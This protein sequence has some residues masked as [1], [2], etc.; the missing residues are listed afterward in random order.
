MAQAR[1]SGNVV[2]LR[3][4]AAAEPV[5][6]ELAAATGDATVRVLYRIE[7]RPA[8]V[9][10]RDP[11]APGSERAVRGSLADHAVELDGAA[12]A[13][14]EHA[15]ETSPETI[16]AACDVPS[17]EIEHEHRIAGLRTQVR[18]LEGAEQ[19]LRDVFE[20]VELVVIAMDLDARM[21]YVNPFT[22]RLSGWTRDELLGGNWFATFQ[23]GREAFLDRVRAGEFPPRDESTIIV[24][25]GDRRQ[26]DWYN[27]ALRDEEG[28]VEGVLGIGRDTTDELGMQR[29]LEAALGGCT[30]SSRRSSL[31]PAR[32]TSTGGDLC[33][34]VPRPSE[35]LDA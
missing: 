14:I 34:R 28:R 13:A 22:E 11:R 7:E 16:G 27:V 17:A 6:A 24:K 21:T 29:S 25:N 5:A 8:L 20:A 32:S 23:S 3:S 33:Q 1:I 15:A 2:R 35:R 18:M 19:R 10:R 12:I 30:T 9:G 26:I 4:A 31:S